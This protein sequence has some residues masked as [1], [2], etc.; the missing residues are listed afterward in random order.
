MNLPPKLFYALGAAVL[1]ITILI[2]VVYHEEFL[3]G[4]LLG[5]S[6]M[7][8]LLMIGIG[9]ARSLLEKKLDDARTQLR[10]S[11]GIDLSA[12]MDKNR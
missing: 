6:G 7:L 10:D 1:L 3:I 8:S 4:V 5:V 2:G 12:I 9:V 11:V